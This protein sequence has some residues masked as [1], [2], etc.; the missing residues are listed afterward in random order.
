MEEKKV[1][2]QGTRIKE[3]VPYPWKMIVS[4]PFQSL[5]HGEEEDDRVRGMSTQPEEYLGC[6]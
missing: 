5:L 1:I 4:S 2:A 3:C 6:L